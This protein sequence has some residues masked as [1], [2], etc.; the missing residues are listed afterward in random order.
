MKIIDKY[1]QTC[2]IGWKIAIVSLV[3][4]LCP[5]FLVI[6]SINSDI[7]LLWIY[8]ATNVIAS[9]SIIYSIGFAKEKLQKIILSLLFVLSIP[10]NIIVWSNL[11]ITRE[12]MRVAA[13]WVVFC[14]DIRETGEFLSQFVDIVNII[15]FIAYVTVGVFLIV[16]MKNTKR[17]TLKKLANKI[18]FPLS[19]ISIFIIMIFTYLVSA[20]PVFA[21]YHSFAKF[22]AYN[23]Q[24]KN[25]HC[26]SNNMQAV[27][28][29]LEKIPHTFVVVIGESTSLYHQSIYGY[30]RQTTPYQDVLKDKK[31]LAVYT[32]VVTPHVSTRYS[33]EKVLSFSNYNEPKKMLTTPNIIDITKYNCKTYWINNQEIKG[34]WQSP[35][36]YICAEN[37][38]S[39]IDI[40]SETD[41]PIID[42]FGKVL[43]D[44]AKNKVIFI[45]LKGN[46]FAYQNRYSKE[47]EKFNNQYK[48]DENLY[49]NA[50]HLTDEMRKTIDEYDNSILFGDYLLHCIIDSL[51]KTNTSSFVIFFSDHGEELYEIGKF[52]GHNSGFTP[53]QYQY[54]IPFVIWCSEKYRQEVPEVVIDTSRAYNNE[55]FIHS[56]GSLMRLK[57]PA[58]DSTRS[59][60]SP[61][62]TPTK[63]RVEGKEI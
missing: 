63:R 8:L 10:G 17:Y 7:N 34:M 46:H 15:V 16:K 11:Y 32:D 30:G 49:K 19:I 27:E 18:F 4:F 52:I 42:I 28:C 6:W 47:F 58:F 50:T 43:Q 25:M 26:V 41:Y 23:I 24:I 53:T 5:V 3:F 61:C 54:K 45:H 33:L 38:D 22:I 35:V 1:K 48:H 31:V 12:W 55:D 14:T 56:L 51:N 40:A 62:F 44:T 21:F 39:L 20:C 2:T 13:F 37:A 60:F 29:Y 59:I 57:H 9:I 36:S